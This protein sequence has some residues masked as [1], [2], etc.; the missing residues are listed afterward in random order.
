MK[1]KKILLFCFVILISEICTAQLYNGYNQEFG[2]NRI[3]FDEFTW[4]HYDFKLFSVYFY[5]KGATN[6]S[7]TAQIS[8]DIIKELEER[9]DYYLEDKI[10]FVLYNSLSHYR[11]TNVAINDDVQYNIGGVT[12]QRDSKV[13]LYFDGNHNNL[14]SQVR[15][16]VTDII[17]HRLILGKNWWAQVRNS[18]MLTIPD[19]YIDGLVSYVSDPDNKLVEDQVR[20]GVVTGKF[21]DFNR[22]SNEQSLYA[23]HGIWSYVART[24]G[25][26]VI[27]NILYMSRLSRN[28][29]SGFLYVIGLSLKSLN[30]EAI[31]YYKELYRNSEKYSSFPSQE[32]KAKVSENKKYSQLK[33]S[34][35][36]K[37]V[38]YVENELG[39]YQVMLHEITTGKTKK[40]VSGGTKT[41]WMPDY[42]Y[43]VVQWNPNGKSLAIVT[44]KKA[45]N[46]I[47]FYGL[48]EDEKITKPL[49][50]V[51]RVLDMVYSP[52]GKSMLLSAIRNGQ[53]DL[54]QYNVLSNF[55]KQLTND[56][57][58]DINPAY[59][60][61]TR[62]I[63]SSNR[64]E[65]TLRIEGRT[66][67]VAATY[68]LFLLD[69]L[70]RN[71]VLKRVTN[72]PLINET[73]PLRKDT[74]QFVYLS[75]EAQTVGRHVA[76]FDSVISHIDTAFHYRY[77]TVSNPMT[78]Y[79]RNIIEHDFS[80]NTDMMVQLF[81]KSGKYNLSFAS[82]AGA[83]AVLPANGNGNIIE[84]IK[85]EK[86]AVQVIMSNKLEYQLIA[87]DEINRVE[88]DYNDYRF[89]NEMEKFSP[90]PLLV[91]IPEEG[92]KPSDEIIKP[93]FDSSN[94]IDGPV[95]IN[96]KN[97]K[98]PVLK[99]YDELFSAVK[100]QV[101][102]NFNYSSQMYQRY[103][104]SLG[105]MNTKLA[106]ESY[107]TMSDIFNNHD[108][109]VGQRLSVDGANREF[110]LIYNNRI[111]KF[112]KQYRLERQA[113]KFPIGA[114]KFKLEY[115]QAQLRLSYPFNERLRIN[116]TGM[117]RYDRFIV[118]STEGGTLTEPTVAELL[119][120]LKLE[121]VYD[122]TSSLGLNLY[123]GS[124]FKLFAET[125]NGIF[126]AQYSEGTSTGD[127][128]I[129]GNTFGLKP[130]TII[131]GLD[132]RKYIKVHRNIVWANRIVAS[133]SLGENKL[134][135]Y[136]GGVDSKVHFTD[137]PRFNYDLQV[138]D[139]QLYNFQTVAT[140][141]RG[142]MQ[143]TRNGNNMVMISSELRIPIFSY[144]ATKPVKSDFVKNFQTVIFADVGSAWSGQN[145]YSDDNY[146]NT[147]V[148]G[149]EE[150]DPVKVILRN[151]D[152][153][154]I[155]GY[156]FG[157][158]SRF[159]SYFIKLDFAW[160]LEDG[161][162]NSPKSYL[163]VGL[164]F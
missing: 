131:L 35:D 8:E 24:Y 3:Q 30:Q 124:R 39:K 59:L 88:V 132:Y 117:A 48:D 18:S 115:N 123:N 151:Q 7:Y 76:Y 101:E 68:D 155:S 64:Y 23:G 57:Y 89:A 133:T 63:F 156:G 36:G 33:V 86:P 103:T 98:L 74:A 69:I 41:S 73:K 99:E 92:I 62:V 90:K 5:E 52:D 140:N 26:K 147:T 43:P 50:K 17:I 162:W 146:F 40:I 77:V 116:G 19:W 78:S 1:L 27:P 34:S 129:F 136:M 145:P 46:F 107:V 130:S 160:G 87:I 154:I 110:Y 126:E 158:R 65:D 96:Q 118:L 121:L 56:I 22:L 125:Y 10:E 119:G 14:E 100:F 4:N 66:E 143:N 139:G 44:E 37:Y 31:A 93:E 72:T 16:G 61:P 84:K 25:E 113:N 106:L 152:E 2:K 13:F 102:L 58:D 9:F 47:T 128:S 21:K 97:F 32:L 141:V 109:T 85:K 134:L 71:N 122:N 82:I 144:F 137:R 20:D 148:V 49:L 54:Y 12:K 83:Q 67:P 38:V 159:L 135:Y 150:G 164:D 55:Q 94:L 112:D 91:E 142:F 114:N 105:Y 15:A 104:G 53:T 29:E 45:K 51:D 70:S 153:P 60:S 108:I 120:G 79:S 11:Q 138:V 81:F 75:D 95:T 28:V 157:F 127:S 42:S 163:S 80:S 149:G 6:A 111:G 161:S